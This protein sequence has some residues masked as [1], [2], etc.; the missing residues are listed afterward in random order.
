MNLTETSTYVYGGVETEYH[1]A[2]TATY[3]EQAAFVDAVTQIV[4]QG[5]NYIPLLKDIAFNLKLV[6][7]F[8][9]I[10]MQQFYIDDQFSL[11]AFETFDK[12]TNVSVML[13]IALIDNDVVTN[14]MQSVD[15]NIAYKTGIRRDDISTAIV[16]L[17]RT[18]TQKINSIGENMDMS[19]IAEFVKKFNES[20]FDG[21]SLVNAYMNSEQYKKNVAE[22][23]D[24]KNEKIRKLQQ[25]VNAETA[26]NVV[27]DKKPINK[28]AS[29]S[30]KSTANTR[31]KADSEGK[32][33]VVK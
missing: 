21:E 15:D 20:G 33:K 23:V 2:T 32:I 7:N 12:E 14:L 22:V 11:D 26:K 9:D 16:E 3:T 5:G 28:T 25:Q 6:Q 30:V 31:K 10:D 27:T 13:K 1:Y 18:F 29:K 24:A 19:A 17:I 8:T 4:I